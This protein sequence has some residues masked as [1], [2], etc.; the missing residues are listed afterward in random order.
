[1]HQ[2]VASGF[3]S[4]SGRDFRA[5]IGLRDQNGLARCSEPHVLELRP[6][7]QH[8]YSDRPHWPRKVATSGA[9]GQ[10]THSTAR[11]VAWVALAI[12]SSI[13]FGRVSRP[14][15]NEPLVSAITLGA[16]SFW[17]LPWL[18]FGL[19]CSGLGLGGGGGGFVL[20]GL[21][22]FPDAVRLLMLDAILILHHPVGRGFA[23][24]VQLW[25]FLNISMPRPSGD[26]IESP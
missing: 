23:F 20:P 2:V 15:F 6:T 16:T 1:M 13:P 21:A 19:P 7:V 14:Q 8:F 9:T 10:T 5:V 17:F 18:G 4:L 3:L 12:V 25:V 24:F 22:G 26:L 11:P